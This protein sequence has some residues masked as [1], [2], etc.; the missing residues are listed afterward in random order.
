[1]VRKFINVGHVMDMVI[2]HLSVLKERKSIE[3]ISNLQEMENL[4]KLMKKMI[5]INKQ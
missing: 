1:M 2:M 5:L 3:V 4:C